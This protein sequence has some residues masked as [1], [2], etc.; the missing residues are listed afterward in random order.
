MKLLQNDIKQMVRKNYAAI[1]QSDKCSCCGNSSDI[2]NILDLGKKLDYTNDELAI[3]LG[4][5]NLGLGC[6]NPLTIADLKPGETVLDLGSGAGFDAFLAAKSVGKHGKVI[7]V[8]MT[9]EMIKKAKKNA[10]KMGAINVEFRLGEIEKLPLSDNSV[11]VVLSNCVI[12]LSPDKRAVFGEIF[13][14]LKPGGRISI[15]D[16]LRSGEIPREIM[17]NP[18]AY[19]G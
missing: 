3:G 17:D 16:V 12:N 7:G 5:A 4:D 14:V 18:K 13:R 6:G 15:S 11:D 1:A 9:Q 10:D 2:A 19:T 8:D